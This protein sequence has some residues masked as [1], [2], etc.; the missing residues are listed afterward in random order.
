MV[1]IKV[2]LNI[3]LLE[4]FYN[5]QFLISTVNSGCYMTYYIFMLT[6]RIYALL[7]RLYYYVYTH[8]IIFIILLSGVFIFQSVINIIIVFI[9]VKTHKKQLLLDR[10]F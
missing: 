3:Y 7:F 9:L 5:V 10:L 1:C 2:N 4:I 6:Y 8:V